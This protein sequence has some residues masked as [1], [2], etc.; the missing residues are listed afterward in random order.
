MV[1][2]SH[3]SLDR[4][5]HA[6]SD[7]TRRAILSRLARGPA[8]VTELAEP[9]ATSLPAVSKH[10]RVLEAAG[11]MTRTIKGR[12]HHC[13]LQPDPLR[14]AASWIAH[15]RRFWDDRLQALESFLEKTHDRPP[16]KR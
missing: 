7:P 12:E 14:D 16:R 3:P 4:I 2:H 10:L 6:L 8:L 1:Y 15:Y 5:F 11:L 9:F 13:A